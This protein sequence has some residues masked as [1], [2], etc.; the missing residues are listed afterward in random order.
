MGLIGALQTFAQCYLI[1]GGRYNS[2][3]LYNL[4]LSQKA[5]S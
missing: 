4:Y 3:L 5:F 2:G 1:G